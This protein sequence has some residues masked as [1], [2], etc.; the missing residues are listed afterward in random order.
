MSIQ[1]CTRRPIHAKRKV[2]SEQEVSKLLSFAH[3]QPN[4]NDLRDI[5]HIVTATG[6]RASEL[7]NLLWSDINF[8]TRCIAIKTDNS[9]AVRQVPFTRKVSRLL[10][11]RQKR[12]PGSDHVFGLAPRRVL[13]RVSHQLSSFAVQLC[14]RRITL[15]GLR[16]AFATTWVKAGGSILSLASI[17]GY[18]SSL[19]KLRDFASPDQ[20]FGIDSCELKRIERRSP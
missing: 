3:N 19:T 11:A 9:M 7:C 20:R 15:H 12:Q 1:K 14:A 6:L 2:P 17:L 16:H 5:V 8:K 10:R 18:R 13:D 4:T